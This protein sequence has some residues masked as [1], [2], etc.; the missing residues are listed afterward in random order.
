MAEEPE[1]VLPQEWLSAAFRQVEGC[2]HRTVHEEH[3]RAGDERSYGEHEEDS[4]SNLHPDDQ[5]QAEEGHPGGPEVDRSGEKVDASHK[6]G[7]ELE[8]QC[9][10]PE[11]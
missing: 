10:K 1:E 4:R 7:G 8:R 6:E 2:P 3:H 11:I 5:R 9:Q